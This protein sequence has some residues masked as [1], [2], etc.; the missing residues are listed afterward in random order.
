MMVWGIGI[1]AVLAYL[2]YWGASRK[3][4]ADKISYS[5]GF[6]NFKIG[7]TGVTFDYTVVIDN[8]TKSTPKIS[9][10][11][12]RVYLNDKQV[13][14]TDASSIRDGIDLKT[15]RTEVK[16]SY[17]IPLTNLVSV[18]PNIIYMVTSLITGGKKLGINLL[19]KV[20]MRV[21]GVEAEV[22]Q[23]VFSA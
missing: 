19:A 11:Y 8:P 23:N 17:A 1:S 9:T 18:L 3:S 15:G 4:F 6:S 10:P 16:G 20:Y 14:N 13:G 12:V 2:V 22:G 21:D 5:V 7:L